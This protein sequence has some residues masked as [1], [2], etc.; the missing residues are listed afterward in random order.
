MG[1]ERDELALQHVALLQLLANERGVEER[2]RD[3]AD[4]S[5]GIELILV[6]RDYSA[7]AAE[8]E[9]KAAT[10]A[11]QWQREFN[12]GVAHIP[13]G[14]AH[15]IPSV[16]GLSEQG[17]TLDRPAPGEASRG[18]AGER[19]LADLAEL[20]VIASRRDTVEV[21]RLNQVDADS[22]EEGLRAEL[23]LPGQRHLPNEL[24]HLATS[25]PQTDHRSAA[26]RA[27]AA[28]V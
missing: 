20:G 28:I 16:A 25:A 13:A 2:R 6:D 17:G 7:T 23:G 24:E 3:D 19:E 26:S 21:E 18:G 11:D 4:G 5:E 8:E 10:V 9:P 15:E 1:R 14:D 27:G 22:F 12:G